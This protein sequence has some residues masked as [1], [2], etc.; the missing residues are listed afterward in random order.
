[1]NLNQII[2]ISKYLLILH[3]TWNYCLLYSPSNSD[4]TT[5]H[6]PEPPLRYV[7]HAY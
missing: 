5:Y 4:K 7:I 3:T 1:M 6:F 2:E